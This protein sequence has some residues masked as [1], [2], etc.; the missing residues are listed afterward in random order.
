MPAPAA[1]CA[2]DPARAVLSPATSGRGGPNINPATGLST[3]YLNHFTEAVMVLDMVGA[4]LECLD[5]LQAW[6][7]KTYAEHFAASG[8]T[9]RD[10]IVGTYRAADPEVRQALDRASEM[11]NAMVRQA[12]EMV[13]QHAGTPELDAIARRATERL[14]PLLV[15]TAAVINGTAADSGGGQGPQAAIDAMFGR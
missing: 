10:A 9:N 2:N 14:R 7:P 3:D 11:L 4:M 1:D 8:F 13:L 5:D 15:R 6:Q 12:R